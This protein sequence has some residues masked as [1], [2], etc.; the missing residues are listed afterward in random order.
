LATD[1]N[2]KQI[3]VNV[4]ELDHL[5]HPGYVARYVVPSEQ[6]STI[7][8]E[9]EGS[10]ILQSFS[11]VADWINDVWRGLY[12]RQEGSAETRP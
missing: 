4:T 2:G 10:A 3:V 1:Q 12:G 5:L 7:H 6:G 9:G 8:N 11:P